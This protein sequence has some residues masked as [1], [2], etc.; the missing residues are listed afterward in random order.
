MKKY[1]VALNEMLAARER[2]AAMQ[3][4]LMQNGSCLIC[5]TMNIAGDVKRTPLIRLCFDE[6]M[7]A[8]DAAFAGSIIRRII[9]DDVTGPE[10]YVLVDMQAAD[11]KAITRSIE[12]SFP[13]ARLFDMDVMDGAGKISREIQRSCLVCS[14]PAQE[15]ARSRTHGLDVIKEATQRLLYDCGAKVLGRAGYLSLLDELYATPKPGLVD[16]QN[17]G[18][19]RDMDIGLFEISAEAIRPFFEQAAYMGML[20]AGMKT[21]R[22]AGIEGEQAMLE[23]TGGVNTH[24]GMV[25]SMGLL[26]AGM[27]K[28][29]TVGGDPVENAVAL[30][31]EDHDQRLRDAMEEPKTNGNGAYLRYGAKGAVGEAAQ[32]F[33]S[34]Q[35][36][37]ERLREYTDIGEDPGPLALCDVMCF[38]EDTNL[39]HRGGREGLGFVQMRAREISRLPVGQRINELNRLDTE[40]T[41]RN[42]SPG[43]SADMLALGYL[44]NRW[45]EIAE[46]LF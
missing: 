45:R 28:A 41:E 21:L 33:K 40:L 11:V 31:R 10:G 36:A 12:E 7:K 4:E 5:F 23:A 24:K 32:G 37:A 29:V 30:A 43:G 26:L 1:S 15:C 3:R 8:L 13:A 35:F 6:G 39:L 18:A 22:K 42:L 34:A 9:I 25:Y 17:N 20:D 27:G 38:L 44:L 16:R 14:R 2:R 46:N 19:H